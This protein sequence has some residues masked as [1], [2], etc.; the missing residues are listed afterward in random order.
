MGHEFF[1]IVED[2]SRAD[3]PGRK[4]VLKKAIWSSRSYD[5]LRGMR[6]LPPRRFQHL[7]ALG[8]IGKGPSGMLRKIYLPA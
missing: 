5:D 8:F 4:S 7:Q 3:Q 1:G 2:V 6:Q